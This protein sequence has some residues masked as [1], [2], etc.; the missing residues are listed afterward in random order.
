LPYLICY[1]AQE[2]QRGLDLDEEDLDQAVLTADEPLSHGEPQHRWAL[3]GVLPHEPQRLQRWVQTA[4]E[5][6]VGTGLGKN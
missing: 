2:K 5:D 6:G 1:V 4:T 3:A